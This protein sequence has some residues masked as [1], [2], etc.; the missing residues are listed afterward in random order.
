M[1]LYCYWSYQ[2]V[3]SQDFI[4]RNVKVRR[5]WGWAGVF[6][7]GLVLG[8]FLVWGIF[9][10]W[11]GF[12]SGF[13]ERR[14]RR[15]AD[16]HDCASY[17][18]CASQGFSKVGSSCWLAHFSFLLGIGQW[19]SADGSVLPLWS[20]LISHVE[21]NWIWSWIA[22]NLLEN[23]GSHKYLHFVGLR[24]LGTMMLLSYQNGNIFCKAL[25]KALK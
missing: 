20:I 6:L 9:F 11:C 22:G 2:I 1:C 25:W 17:F 10:F 13:S 12:A 4:V 24:S 14:E 21:G 16:L 18:A 15:F 7:G 19:T 23:H 8:W 3:D 5:C